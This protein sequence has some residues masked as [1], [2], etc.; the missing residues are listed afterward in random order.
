MNEEDYIKGISGIGWGQDAEATR[1]RL[2]LKTAFFTL[3]LEF[4]Q[5]V[6]VVQKVRRMRVLHR[7]GGVL[8]E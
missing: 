8:V 7:C 5:M 1:T 6:Q 4:L 2:Y 3:S